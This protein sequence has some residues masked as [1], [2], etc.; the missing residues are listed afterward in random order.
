MAPIDGNAP[1]T[2]HYLQSQVIEDVSTFFIE[3]P[4]VDALHTILTQWLWCGS[5][6]ALVDGEAREGKTKAICSLKA[7]LPSRSG[8]QIPVHT[9]IYA[10]RDKNTQRDVWVMLAEN[11]HIKVRPRAPSN[12]LAGPIKT[13]LAES[14][15]INDT[16][17][18]LIVVDE[19]QFL[20]ISQLNVFAEIFND[21]EQ[22]GVNCCIVFVVNK[23][24]F[25]PLAKKLL[26]DSNK[27]LR[28]RFFNTIYHF[29]G[30]RSE[31]EV[32]ACLAQYD[33]DTD[34]DG[35][36][37]IPITQ[38]YF[39]KGYNDGWR[40]VNAANLMWT[41]F[42]ADYKKR[43]QLNAWGMHYFIRAVNVLLMDYLPLHDYHD[44]NQLEG[45]IVQSIKATNIEPQ[46][47]EL[48]QV[49]NVK[50]RASAQK[51]V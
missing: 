32:R 31:K 29:H 40:M 28:D 37:I 22:V 49:H 27:Y 48:Y 51:A 13:C 47:C 24:K 43:L 2:T 15:L 46:L 3:T 6:G 23:D 4:M 39:E 35:N 44:K 18:L 17:Q 11:L 19:S 25:K 5:T 34:S 1:H 7:H 41:V 33:R 26:L 42:C 9:F 30:L 38:A 20:N 12:E 50:H 10:D 36:A 21:L 16:R 45:M 8:Q 14:A